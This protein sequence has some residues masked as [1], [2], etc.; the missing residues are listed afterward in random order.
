ME[1]PWVEHLANQITKQAQR[2]M[3]TGS[4]VACRSCLFLLW[5]FK[6]QWWSPWFFLKLLWNTYL[7][8][9]FVLMSS[10]FV[11]LVGLLSYGKTPG[12]TVG[13][14][15]PVEATPRNQMATSKIFHLK[16]TVTDCEEDYR[17]LCCVRLAFFRL[18]K[19]R[20]DQYMEVFFAKILS[21][22]WP[23]GWKGYSS[24]L[25]VWM[26]GNHSILL[27]TLPCW[28]SFGSKMR[29]KRFYSMKD[30]LGSS[31]STMSANKVHGL[32]YQFT[33]FS[34]PYI[35]HLQVNFATQPQCIHF[36]IEIQQSV[37]GSSLSTSLLILHTEKK[38][39]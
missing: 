2:R 6:Q 13:G 28:W 10:S 34:P 14:F 12:S 15:G 33:M 26:Y 38:G 27:A 23:K 35:T 16:W 20:L 5:F 7:L 25:D 11:I 21:F 22:S 4:L 9:M 30:V 17:P 39:V 18:R 8:D 3:T 37:A 31:S 1:P 36:V 19:R 24:I 32:I 29:G